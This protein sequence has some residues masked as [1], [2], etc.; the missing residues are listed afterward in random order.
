L[1]TLKL[2]KDAVAVAFRSDGKELAV[3]CIDGQVCCFD[4]I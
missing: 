3:S 4:F 1:E 2:S